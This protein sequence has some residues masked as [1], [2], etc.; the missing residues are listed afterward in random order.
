MVLK[1]ELIFQ[2]F[3]FFLSFRSLWVLGFCILVWNI[4]ACGF[5]G[6]SL[7][8]PPTRLPFYLLTQQ[9]KEKLQEKASWFENKIAMNHL[10]REGLLAYEVEIKQNEG[11]WPT[12]FR[13][14]GIWTG[15]YL[16]AQGFRFRVTGEK[17]AKERISRLSS[18]IE[19]LV[20]V[21]GK[22]GLLAR[23]IWSMDDVS[24]PLGMDWR[25]TSLDPRI[26]WLSDVSVDQIAGVFFGAG[27]AFDSIDDPFIKRKIIGWVSAMSDHL[28]D[29]GMEIR[30]ITGKRTKHGDLTCGWISEDLNC[31][32]ALSVVKVAWHITGENRFEEAY[33]NLVHR[34]YPER[35]ISARRPWWEVVLGE[36]HSDNNLAFLAYYNLLHYEK[37]T[38]LLNLY[39]KSLR[40]SWRAVREEKNPFFTFLYHSL[41]PFTDWDRESMKEALETLIL[42][43]IDRR[44]TPFKISQNQCVSFWR[45]RL[46]RKQACSPI[47]INQRPQVG[48]EWNENPSRLEGGG[49][50]TQGFSGFDYLLAYWMGRYHGFIDRED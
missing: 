26:F 30:D 4:Q 2:N 35:S 3:G 23:G 34:G 18:G 12:S 27:V 37:D 7:K 10:T 36:N 17:E 5:K 21:T 29:N 14:M 43:P 20:R 1:V 8:N 9:E 39:R 46:G 41:M 25:Q 19:L 6:E 49:D 31:L 11:V 38:R 24:P 22:S 42:F 44:N 13:D 48:I 32:I 40:R 47:P 50:G 15:T 16:A 28:L 33:K 45:D